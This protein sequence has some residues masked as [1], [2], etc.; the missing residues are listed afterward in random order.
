MFLGDYKHEKVAKIKTAAK[1]KLSIFVRDTGFAI[2]DQTTASSNPVSYLHQC[3]ITYTSQ[4]GKETKQ[5]MM[6]LASCIMLNMR[7]KPLCDL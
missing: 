6:Y 3:R 4:K 5:N 2:S 1:T 7:G